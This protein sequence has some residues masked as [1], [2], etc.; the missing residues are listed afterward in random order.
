MLHASCADGPGSVTSRQPALDGPPK[1][2]ETLHARRR[3]V[4]PLPS[5][6]FHPGHNEGSSEGAASPLKTPTSTQSG[7]PRSG[8]HR[9]TGSEF[10]G[11]DGRSG[12]A[13]LLSSSPTKGDGALPHPRAGP[14]PGKPEG[15]RGHSHRRSGAISCHDVSV[16]LQPSSQGHSTRAE[17][18]PTSPV[19]AHVFPGLE[20]GL[21]GSA[22]GSVENGSVQ[23]SSQAWR[24]ARRSAGV[25]PRARVG[26][27]DNV[28]FI[29][30]PLSTL[31][32]ETSSSQT[33]IHGRDSISGSVSSMASLGSQEGDGPA[34]RSSGDDE[35]PRRRPTTAGPIMIRRRSAEERPFGDVA[36][37]L[38]R[39]NSSSGS[40]HRR[41]SEKQFGMPAENGFQPA[42]GNV[43]GSAPHDPWDLE[44]N[45]RGSPGLR[46][47]EAS[48]RELGLSLD[49][50][51]DRKA[52]KKN[53]K[54]VRTW[55][56]AILSRKARLGRQKPKP[57]I[58]R[59]PTPP[60]R[61]LPPRVLSS[62]ID[63]DEDDASTAG[64]Q[65]FRFPASPPI[66]RTAE[67]ASAYSSSSSQTR[68]VSP[69]IDLDAALA[70]FDPS[71]MKQ[72]AEDPQNS[73]FNKA[74]RRMHSFGATGGF[75]GPGM[76]YH[77][78]TESAPELIGI[79][80]RR[81]SL[82]LRNNPTMADVFEEDEEA[83]VAKVH[84]PNDPVSTFREVEYHSD[85]LRVP[86]VDS[87]NH[88]ATCGADWNLQHS[89]PSSPKSRS[90]EDI[91]QITAN[92]SPVDKMV[93]RARDVETADEGADEP[94][95][96]SAVIGPGEILHD[97]PTVKT[98]SG[99]I[100]LVLENASR[101]SVLDGPA[102]DRLP[103][104]SYDYVTAQ[105]PS[106]TTSAVASPELSTRVFDQSSASTPNLFGTG[107]SIPDERTMQPQIMGEVNAEVR[108]SADDVP[109]L[110]S[111]RS[112]MTSA[113]QS[114]AGQ[115]SRPYSNDGGAHGISVRSSSIVS[116]ATGRSCQPSDK[117]TPTKRSSLV[118]LSKLVGGSRG[119][120]SKLSIEQHAQPDSPEK[121]G[122]DK[123][124]KF[125]RFVTFWRTKSAG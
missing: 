108:T 19:D 68:S 56:G 83:E 102:S 74:K 8:G 52:G 38:E 86:A 49:R 10:I 88:T 42:E 23:P 89:V 29:P 60:L 64:S 43:A 124:G 77:R 82:R 40:P 104:P 45:G 122:K 37:A 125:T 15:R 26:F 91:H 72:Q 50:K 3:S 5:F 73:R 55:A 11:G 78:R 18:A 2:Q 110:A 22:G 93:E 14:P 63:F 54:G 116:G 114:Y 69:I 101:N 97:Q 34:L 106:V 112:T 31:S 51:V 30:R 33:T 80:P 94:T 115:S 67:Q 103:S 92:T 9:R 105:T 27:S 99:P 46:L 96:A 100:G 75:T 32:S 111:S 59:T 76:H 119:E 35:P 47:T 12:G 87:P 39:P 95:R 98:S 16:I 36:S 81:S 21:N 25:F 13:G 62:A 117:S 85:L 6:D 20:S 24:S 58:R 28:E 53:Q 107:Y 70:P 17:S 109:S 121:A 79:E 118:S 1:P 123:R 41:H 61:N 71:Y 57:G 66:A 65:S 90:H 7:P 84:L 120:K 44:S 113:V 4:V 48:T